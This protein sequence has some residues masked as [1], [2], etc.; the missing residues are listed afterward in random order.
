[1]TLPVDFDILRPSPSTTNP[2]VSTARYGARSYK[3][4][5]GMSEA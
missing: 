1:M 4:T 2:C 3:A 5:D